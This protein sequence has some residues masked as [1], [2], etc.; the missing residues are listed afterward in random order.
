MSRRRDQ[1]LK[2]TT[3]NIH[4]G[5]GGDRHFD[6]GRIAAVLAEIDADV[7][8]LQEVGWHRRTH[9]RVDQ[10]ATALVLWECLTGEKLFTGDNEA[11]I[12][13]KVL[14]CE[15]KPPSAPGSIARYR[16]LE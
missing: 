15:V 16:P 3:W 5:I 8:G 14:T 4:S 6:M 1:R 2:F 7:V 11:I 12:L 9:H 10:F 13:R